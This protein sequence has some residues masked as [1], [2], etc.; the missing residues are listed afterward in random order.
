MNFHLAIEGT[1]SNGHGGGNAY[2]INLV[3]T[4]K[5]LQTDVQSHKVDNERLM[6]AKYQQEEFSMNLMKI[7]DIIEKKLEKESGSN[8]SGI[9]KTHK[10]KE[11]L[12][13]GIRHHH[14]YQM[15]SNRRAHSI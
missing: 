9:H 15:N 14:H 4:I 7:L 8:E 10:E 6:K 11:I 2:A 5:K 12:R 1:N 3:E 13:G